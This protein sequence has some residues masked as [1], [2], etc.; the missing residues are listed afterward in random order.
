MYRLKPSREVN[1]LIESVVTQAAKK[2]DIKIIAFKALSSHWH[3][4]IKD[5]EALHPRFMQYVNSLLARA[6]NLKQDTEDA[7]WTCHTN[8]AVYLPDA[9]SLLR[10]H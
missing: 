10:W 6:L 3:A 2:Y 7:F 9:E 8:S 1:E 4:I 5:V